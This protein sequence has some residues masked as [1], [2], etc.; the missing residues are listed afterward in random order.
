MPS[1]RLVRRAPSPVLVALAMLT[2]SSA[3]GCTPEPASWEIALDPSIAPSDV[4]RVS[5]QIF[6]GGCESQT[7]FSPEFVLTPSMPEPM[8]TIALEDGRRFGLYAYAVN[9]SCEIIAEGCMEVTAPIDNDLVLMLEPIDAVDMCR[10]TGACEEGSCSDVFSCIGASPGEACGIRREMICR[11]DP[12]SGELEC[13]PGTCGDGFVSGDEECDP[14]DDTAGGCIACRYQCTSLDDCD[15]GNDC[16]V[17]ELCDVNH[18]CVA[19]MPRDGMGETCEISASETGYCRMGMCASVNC[20]NGITE[21]DEDCDDGNTDSGDGC[22]NNCTFSCESDGQ[23]D[24]ELPCNGKE[25]CD[26]A[27][28]RCVDP[29]DIDCDDRDP[30]TAD[31]CD[32]TAPIG[33]SCRSTLM[34][35]M[36]GDQYSSLTGCLNGRDCNDD[37]RQTHPGAPEQCDSIDNDCD[38]IVDEAIVP[39]SCYADLDGD[40]YGRNSDVASLCDCSLSP[41]HR[42]TVGGDCQDEPSFNGVQ[43]NPSV[44]TYSSTAYCVPV[45]GTCGPGWDWNCDGMDSRRYTTIA[46]CSCDV[47]R[48]GWQTAVP[49]CGDMGTWITCGRGTVVI[50]VMPTKGLQPVCSAAPSSRRQECR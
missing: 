4:I 40:G 37:Q 2:L 34:G 27:M 44:T 21:S 38:M 25:T 12:A 36:D 16:T 28:H 5:A 3:L 49:A 7:T 23:C 17:G 47:F 41:V 24:D 9:A 30:C 26:V 39:I 11:P 18:R 46:D 15:D 8:S 13:V 33:E 29:P 1:R 42:V 20:G 10:G 43:V 35:D 19:P 45:G 50:P 48:S 31:V 22:E 6:E 14:L 32:D